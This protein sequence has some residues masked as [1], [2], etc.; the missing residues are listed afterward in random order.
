[1]ELLPQK[2]WLLFL[3]FPDVS[4]QLHLPRFLTQ[5]DRKRYSASS[6]ATADGCLFNYSGDGIPL[7]GEFLTL[8]PLFSQACWGAGSLVADGQCENCV[9][10][11]RQSEDFQIKFQNQ[12]EKA[13]F[14]WERGKGVIEN[15]IISSACRSDFSLILLVRE[16]KSTN[17][18]R[19]W[20]HTRLS[21]QFNFNRPRFFSTEYHNPDI[22]HFEKFLFHFVSFA[23]MESAPFASRSNQN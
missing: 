17:S 8:H 2:Q 15:S 14:K 6:L 12:D 21:T 18:W 7:A 20:F 1:M 4:P 22:I 16:E 23:R 5:Q 10:N 11:T 13:S 19:R 3:F 9:N